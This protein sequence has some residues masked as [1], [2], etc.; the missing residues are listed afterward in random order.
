M[1][2]LFVIGLMVLIASCDTARNTPDPEESFFMRFYGDDGNQEAVDMIINDDGTMIL[3]G[4]SVK[5]NNKPSQV[6][7][8]KVTADG[9][10]IWEKFFDDGFDWI[11]KDIEP[12]ATTGQYVIAA[13]KISSV[14]GSDFL[15]FTVSDSGA[16]AL[17]T[18]T[19]SFTY[20]GQSQEIPV[21]VTQIY[22]NGSGS[23]FI[24]TGSTNYDNGTGPGFEGIT[25]VFARFDQSCANYT[26]SWV[27]NA[28]LESD[29]YGVRVIQRADL[30]DTEPFV[31]FGYKNSPPV[32]DISNTSF[33]FWF[34]KMSEV[35]GNVVVSSVLK[36]SPVDMDEELQSVSTINSG[37]LANYILTGII[38]PLTT[39]QERIFVSVVKDAA[40]FAEGTLTPQIL[41]FDLGDLTLK[42]SKFKSTSSSALQDGGYIIA[43]NTAA[44][45]D[46]EMLLMK[47]NV[48]GSTQWS[49]PILLGGQGDDWQVVVHELPD[50]R[51]LL[52][53]TMQIGDD[54]QSKMALCKLN[55]N[56]KFE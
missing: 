43:A 9:F 11:A 44:S 2:F 31:F 21:S 33:N 7:L 4:T 22:D 54:R 39:G 49:D 28:G 42:A 10:V 45:G 15:I 34:S 3:L 17:I 16:D 6:Y 52:F 18:N 41:P 53:G 25:A 55:R 48:D 20:P 47:L 40:L 5:T 56:G 24:V 26:G 23:G 19:G 46:S 36:D 1:R 35:G 38:S 32:D 37:S 12:T 13:E 50:K 30:N 14:T 8:V 27:E 51:I 29:D